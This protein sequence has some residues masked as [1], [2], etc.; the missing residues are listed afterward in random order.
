VTPEPALP[1]G[2]SNDVAEPEKPCAAPQ[3]LHGD[4]RVHVERGQQRAT[5]R[6]S[7]R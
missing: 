2:E 7:P 5:G 6:D 3:D 4:A 1:Y